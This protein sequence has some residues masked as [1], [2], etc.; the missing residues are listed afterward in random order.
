MIQER[1][2]TLLQEMFKLD[3]QKLKGDASLFDD[4][5]LDSIDVIDLLT[6]LNDEFTLE[7][8]PFDFENC[9]TLDQFLQKL[10]QAGN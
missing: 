1:A 8:S 6:Q 10:N 7:L 4:L 2:K 3:P 5:D 9:Q